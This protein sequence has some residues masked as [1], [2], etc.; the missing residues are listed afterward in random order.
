MEAKNF[1]KS[2]EQGKDT[3]WRLRQQPLFLWFGIWKADAIKGSQILESLMLPACWEIAHE[4]NT[5]LIH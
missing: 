5:K 3:Q 1:L 4:Y 2:E